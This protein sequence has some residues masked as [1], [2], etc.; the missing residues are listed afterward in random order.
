VNNSS[1]FSRRDDFLLLLK[2]KLISGKKKALLAN[3]WTIWKL[4]SLKK[5]ISDP[6]SGDRLEPDLVSST[7]HT[8][9]WT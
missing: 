7:V 8:V 2:K 6:D 5:L 4:L 9:E 3:K 1:R